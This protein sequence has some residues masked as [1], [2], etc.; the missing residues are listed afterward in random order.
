MRCCDGLAHYHGL[1][2]G[3][4][5]SSSPH[6]ASAPAH[7]QLFPSC[8]HLCPVRPRPGNPFPH[9]PSSQASGVRQKFLQRG[10]AT[11]QLQST[12]APRPSR[13]DGDSKE[14]THH[15]VEFHPRNQLVSRAESKTS[16]RLSG[17]STVGRAQGCRPRLATYWRIEGKIDSSDSTSGDEDVRSAFSGE[18][19]CAIPA[20]GPPPAT[21]IRHFRNNG[22]DRP[23]AGSESMATK[24]LFLDPKL[25]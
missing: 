14:V 7:P 15:L 19:E 17:A 20:A 2:F 24:L 13:A 21:E 8:L 18:S 3:D 16:P 1:P 4:S 6:A 12:W 25:S 9:P 11:G 23:E 5:F 10:S 22:P